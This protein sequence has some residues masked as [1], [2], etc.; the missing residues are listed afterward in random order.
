[1]EDDNIDLRDV[2]H[3]QGHRGTQAHGHRQGGGL[4]EHLEQRENR[5][6]VNNKY[7]SIHLDILQ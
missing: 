4:D 1:M 7:L 5:V 3:A 2:Q 6:K